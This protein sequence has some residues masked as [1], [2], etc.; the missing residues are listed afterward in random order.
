MAEVGAS[1]QCRQCQ[2]LTL[3]MAMAFEFIRRKLK[4]ASISLIILLLEKFRQTCAALHLSPQEQ[5]CT[6]VAIGDTN[7]IGQLKLSCTAIQSPSGTI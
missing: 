7:I 3:S 4:C 5:I 2:P 1:E 6:F